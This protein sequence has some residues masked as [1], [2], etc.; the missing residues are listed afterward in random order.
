[1][2]NPKTFVK[3]CKT[4][5]NHR[6]ARAL[7]GR[8]LK[9]KTSITTR[10]CHRYGL[11]PQDV[12]AGSALVF[13]ISFAASA[14]LLF[15]L[16][17]YLSLLIGLLVAYSI[18]SWFLNWIPREL[19]REKLTISYETPLI[20]QEIILASAGS[21]SIFDLAKMV[22]MG[23]HPIV[24]KAFSRIVEHVNNG[25]RPEE[26]VMRYA[27]YQPCETLRRHLMDAISLNLEWSEIKRVL[28]GRRGEAEFEYEKYTMQTETRILL[29]VGF[30]TF[31]PII[32]S[33]A[34]FINNLW[35]N[36]LSMV[37]V[38]LLFSVLLYV[39]QRRLMKP[40]RNVQILGGENSGQRAKGLLNHTLKEEL[41]E[42]IILMSILGE[43][44]HRENVSPE[45]AVKRASE[46]YR[47]W[48]SPILNE[49]TYRIIYDGETFGE[50]WMRFANSFSNPQCRQV[51]GT[52]PLMI[53]RTAEV[54]GER[55][56]D[57][58]SYIKENQT[59]IEERENVLG[60]QRFKA[61]LLSV[62]SSA[63][64]GLIAALSPLFMMVGMR[65]FSLSFFTSSLWS[66][67]AMV[68]VMVLLLMTLTNTFNVA[69]AVGIEK[70]AVYLCSS[71]SVF[72]VVFILSTRMISGFV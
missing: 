61:K 62:F 49:L 64:L 22:V 16:V 60:A 4:A 56:I 66:S 50:A 38:A 53:E 69:K 48:L 17:G 52:L 23:K 7:G 32:F 11:I 35:R 27:N 12:A 6:V 45:R 44:L 5:T 41:Q 57:V 63:A 30:G 70:P 33:I 24:S 13:L 67:D 2:T 54:A 25:D 28:Q 42:T 8:L 1:M 46:I 68:S 39:L 51:L 36:L 3:I 40:V 19:E 43:L 65:Q 37:F 26:L 31:W 55:L 21:E 18:A 14:S 72:L 29:I 20:L 9:G 71:A 58:A 47:G 10:H 59:L 34:I 15:Y